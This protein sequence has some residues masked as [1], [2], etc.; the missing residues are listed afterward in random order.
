MR[1]KPPDFPLK[2]SSE[3]NIPYTYIAPYLDGVYLAINAIPDSFLVYHAHD[4]GYHKA[5]KIT[6]HHDLFSTLLRVDQLKRIARTNIDS[7]EYILGGEDKLSMKILQV[8]ERHKPEMIFVA[9]SNI[10]LV[11]GEDVE[12]VIEDLKTKH[13]IP[14]VLIPGKNIELNYIAG[15]Y[16]TVKSLLAEIPLEKASDKGGTVAL[17]GY[18][19]D[20]N[21]GDHR[22]NISEMKR[23]LAGIGVPPNIVFL[24]GSSVKQMKSSPAPDVVMDL[25]EGEVGG[26]EFAGRFNADYF[27]IGVP[28]G[29]QGTI[30]WI[31]NLAHHL[32]LGKAAREFIDHELSA[33][34]P[35]LQW[36]LP[37]YFYGKSALV[38]AD[39]VFLPL[40]IEFLK[41]LGFHIA[42]TICTTDAQSLKA[43]AT[44]SHDDE[45]KF[46]PIHLNELKNLVTKYAHAG[47]VDLM[48][49]NSIIHQF[50]KDIAVAFVEMGYPSSF[51]HSI[52]QAPFL[53]F[54]GVRTL[55]ERIIN[56][57]EETALRSH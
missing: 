40:M 11:S 4:C 1:S 46:L 2:S 55:V 9:R 27:T 23:M 37:K 14:L 12:S 38:C 57:M 34:I 47:K 42:G 13:G 18:I 10:V 15:Y 50:V 3:F 22:G 24:D 30:R 16:D 43:D 52:H 5:E 53:G 56:G 51:H 49:G 8:F 41:E 31:E 39:H 35:M 20:R 48:I 26:Q 32:N 45:D 44:I 36:L 17:V 28:L 6:A 21:E 25:T 19:F 54:N 33:L 7:K 29:I